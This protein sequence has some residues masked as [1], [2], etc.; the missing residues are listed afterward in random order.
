MALYT[1]DFGGATGA[2]HSTSRGAS[3]GARAT[4]G[5]VELAALE[6]RAEDKA[7]VRVLIVD[8]EESLLESCASVLR[9]EGYQ[10]TTCRKG[11]DALE[12]VQRRPFDV[13]LID[14]YMTQV[15]GIEILN[16]CLATQPEAL[17]I[18]I[19]GNP[20]V[21]SSLEALR[22]G[23]WHYL[24]KPFAASHLQILLA[25]A[26][27]TVTVARETRATRAIEEESGAGERSSDGGLVVLGNSPCFQQMMDLARRV[28]STDA[29]VF[30]SGESGTG[31]ELI[32]QFIHYHSRRG[33][34]PL[35]AV[36]CAALPETLLESEMFGHMKGAFTGAIRDKPGLLETANG[37]TLFLD[38][39]T[40]MPVALQAKLLRV[41][42]D[43]VVRRVGSN[44]TDAVVNV[45]FIAATNRDPKEAMEE[46]TLRKDLYYRLRVV[47]INVPPLRA[48][49]DDIP[50][51][52]RHFLSTYWA[53]HRGRET[54]PWFGREA[55]RALQERAWHG[56]VRELQNVIEH[57][58][59]LA[60]ASV[61]IQ[62]DEI[63]FL[64]EDRAP[65]AAASV[66]SVIG[67]E[68]QYH[69]ARERIIAQFERSYLTWLVSRS[70]GNMSKAARI[71][72]VDRTT[73][74]RLMEKHGLQR[75][76]IIRMHG[77]LT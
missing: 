41:I 24:P 34:R 1:R 44:K 30:I 54:P 63:P 37:G 70:T 25:R 64:D 69:P 57:T 17:V 36:N 29:S 28:A 62:P 42:Q 10:V 52:A 33:S 12:L 22:K 59:V 40:E 21:E 7:S 8:D 66:A 77:Q 48:R 72:G 58:V 51:L 32:A 5:D 45:R 9:V 16:A 4:D 73:L 15:S 3:G 2:R 74:Y 65:P 71:A 55:L 18:M 67:D 68:P 19:T 14:L 49:P 75:D 11:A 43:G 27:H 39:L 6:L 23:A 47:P 31:K 35:V 13:V 56:N 20:S 53:R 26:A 38:E 60:E 46:G 61:E 76:T 50:L